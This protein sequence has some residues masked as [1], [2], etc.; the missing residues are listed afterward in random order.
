MYDYGMII[1]IE[2][3][4]TE[5]LLIFCKD[6]IIS[7][8]NSKIVVDIEN[9]IIEKLQ[10]QPNIILKEIDKIIKP[11]ICIYVKYFCNKVL[12]RITDTGLI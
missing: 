10:I 12:V 8:Q 3:I 1:N 4:K 7:Y 6:L 2:Q 11:Y 5:A 9:E